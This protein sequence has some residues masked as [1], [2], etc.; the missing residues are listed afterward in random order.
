[1]FSTSLSLICQRFNFIY[2]LHLTVYAGQ[3]GIKGSMPGPALSWRKRVKI[4]VGAAKGLDYIHGKAQIHGGIR[5]SNVLLF[6]DNEVAKITDFDL[7]YF[8]KKSNLLL[9]LKWFSSGGKYGSASQKSWMS[10]VYSFG[11]VLLELLTGRKP[12]DHTQPLMQE[13]LV[14]W[15]WIF[16][17]FSYL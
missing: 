15:V 1:M 8:N 9:G 11:V 7:Q 17:N 10:D 13:D 6:D 4:A 3:K 16:L 5:S 14:Q 12:I 2:H